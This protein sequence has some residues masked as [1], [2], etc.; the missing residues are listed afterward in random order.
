MVDVRIRAGLLPLIGLIASVGITVTLLLWVMDG[1]T[2]AAVPEDVYVGI[3]FT[4]VDPFGVRVDEVAL[5]SPA[6]QAGLRAGDM[7][8]TLD[9]SYVNGQA[10]LTRVATYQPNDEIVLGIQR[11]GVEHHLM[12]QLG[13][14]PAQANDNL[15]LVSLDTPRN[16]LHISGVVYDSADRAWHVRQLSSSDTLALNGLQEGDVI[17]HINT[18]TLTSQTRDMLMMATMVEDAA[19]LTVQRGESQLELEVPAIVARLLL[20]D[21]QPLDIPLE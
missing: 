15:D 4:P 7:I 11:N 10:L 21:A 5:N 9:G 16:S 1:T 3:R 18:H 20:V 14:A 19:V 17:T 2:E 6:A 13:T 12:L 8:Y